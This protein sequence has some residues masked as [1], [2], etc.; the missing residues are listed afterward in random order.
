MIE[1]LKLKDNEVVIEFIQMVLF[2][3]QVFS[4]KMYQEA[5][6]VI[7]TFKKGD[8]NMETIV[9]RL[10]KKG[11]EEGMEK[12]M[13]RGMQKGMQKGREEGMEKGALKQAIITVIGLHKTKKFPVEEIAQLTELSLKQIRKILSFYEIHKKDTLLF[14]ENSDFEDIR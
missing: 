1:L 13:E 3:I 5:E 7:E 8:K 6:E 9:D 12:G 14:L 10:L 4:D 2:Y 11:R